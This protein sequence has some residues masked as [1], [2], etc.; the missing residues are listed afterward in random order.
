MF[1]IFKKIADFFNGPSLKVQFE[2]MVL[3]DT[4]KKTESAPVKEDNTIVET[5]KDE[6][7][8]SV[9]TKSKRVKAT[10]VK[11]EVAEAPVKK[12]RAPRK[13]KAE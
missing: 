4:V 12:P 5:V 11:A 13:K 9:T 2:D 3:Q 7:T 6:I 8:D 10:K 1:G